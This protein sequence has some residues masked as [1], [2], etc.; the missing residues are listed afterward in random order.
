MDAKTVQEL[1]SLIIGALLDVTI[2][3]PEKTEEFTKPFTKT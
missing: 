3:N 1:K 2:S